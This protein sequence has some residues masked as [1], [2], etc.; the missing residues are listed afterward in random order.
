MSEPVSSPNAGEASELPLWE[1]IRA[2]VATSGAQALVDLVSV[3]IGGAVPLFIRRLGFDP[4]PASG[5]MLTTVTDT[6]GF[7]LALSFATTVLTQ[8]QVEAAAA[9]SH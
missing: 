2:L 8:I 4:A 5:P 6:C 1:R 3:C 9:A 7:F